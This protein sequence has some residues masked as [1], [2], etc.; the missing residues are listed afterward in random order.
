M[1]ESGVQLTMSPKRVTL[2]TILTTFLKKT[3]L[4]TKRKKK[5]GSNNNYNKSKIIA[6]DI[7]LSS[8]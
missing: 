6:Y 2:V 5:L 4:I 7:F 1:I 8:Y 3:C